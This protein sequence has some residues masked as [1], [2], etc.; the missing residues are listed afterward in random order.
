VTGG[1]FA[2]KTSRTG[3]LCD[4]ERGTYSSTA[5]KR[6]AVQISYAAWL[7]CRNEDASKIMVTE[8]LAFDFELFT[9]ALFLISDQLK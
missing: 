8:I 5:T 6:K 2:L 1:L 4:T 7:K 9:D 3:C